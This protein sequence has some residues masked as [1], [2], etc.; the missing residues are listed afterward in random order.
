V[1][2]CFLR[3]A[4]SRDFVEPSEFDFFVFRMLFLVKERAD[5]HSDTRDGHPRAQALAYPGR[6]PEEAA[7]AGGVGEVL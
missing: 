5:A 7:E 6:L 1:F 2:F 3:F 4:A